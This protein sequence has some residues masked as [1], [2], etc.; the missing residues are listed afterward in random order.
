MRFTILH[1]PDCPSV[2]TLQNRLAEAIAG[3]GDLD[4]AVTPAAGCQ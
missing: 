2:A 4:L 3:A 1:V